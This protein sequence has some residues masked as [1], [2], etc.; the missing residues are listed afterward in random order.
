MTWAC[1]GRTVCHPAQ[2]QAASQAA[3]A[4][5]R[6]L[7]L[8]FL[9]LKDMEAPRPDRRNP[10]RRGLLLSTGLVAQLVRARA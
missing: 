2:N 3:F 5:S 7:R 4:G 1:P 6:R 8:S 9:I 10:R